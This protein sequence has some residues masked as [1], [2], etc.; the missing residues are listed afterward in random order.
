MTRPFRQGMAKLW[1]RQSI[2]MGP[3]PSKPGSLM[4]DLKVQESLEDVVWAPHR[5]TMTIGGKAMFFRVQHGVE[6]RRIGKQSGAG[7]TGHIVWNHHGN[8]AALFH[9]E[10]AVML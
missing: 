9:E 6:I 3:M 10:L 4:S 1:S 2:P 7:P 5:E 8:F